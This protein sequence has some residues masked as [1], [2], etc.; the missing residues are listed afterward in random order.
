M[1]REPSVGHALERT[2]EAGQALLVR[3]IDLLVAESRLF[4]RAGRALGI[5]VVVALLGWLYLME[6]LIDGLAGRHPRFAVEL[7]VGLA[8]AVLAA[9][10]LLRGRQVEHGR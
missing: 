7:C 2:Y 3:R 1:S 5:G 10:L 4:L 8:H 6:G 9:L